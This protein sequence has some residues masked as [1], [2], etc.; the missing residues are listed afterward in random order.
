MRTPTARIAAA[1]LLFPLLSPAEAAAQF[2]QFSSGFA[3]ARVFENPASVSLTPTPNGLDV[4]V[5]TVATD[6]VDLPDDQ[7]LTDF[8]YQ[9]SMLGTGTLTWGSANG[10][11]ALEASATPQFAPP[12]PGGPLQPLPNQENAQAGGTVSFRF[13]EVGIITSQTLPAG[14]PITVDLNCRVDSIGFVLGTLNA[15][16]ETRI[17]AVAECR[18][19]K[20]SGGSL[21]AEIFV[22][23]NEIETKP[24][25]AAVGD[26]L[27]IEGVFRFTGEAYA[28]AVLCCAEYLA[29]TSAELEGSGGLWFG[30][31]AGV[32]LT[33]PSGH[34]YTVPVPEPEP[35]TALPVAVLA[36]GLVRHGFARR[37]SP[38]VA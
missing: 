33:A 7:Y 26:Q 16:N 3:F 10:S 19:I 18:V 2:V 29:E 32:S 34:D 27:A 17:G 35:R 23:G 24:F 4:T 9:A 20:S 6:V 21:A 37:G 30:M 14:T 31:P 1:C 12:A 11:L 22:S 36:L 13:N 25:A 5:G 28:G 15:P 8:V 38:P